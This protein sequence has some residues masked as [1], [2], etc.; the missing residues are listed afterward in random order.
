[1]L[2]REG[3][4]QV[5]SSPAFTSDRYC[6]H[7][8]RLFIGESAVPTITENESL[9]SEKLVIWEFDAGLVFLHGRGEISVLY[10]RLY[11]PRLSPQLSFSSIYRSS[12]LGLYQHQGLW[13]SGTWLYTAFFFFFLSPTLVKTHTFFQYLLRYLP[14]NTISIYTH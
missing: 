11:I 7:R 13:P 4:Q 3:S 12:K 2:G 9:H 10:P 8:T 6:C 5:L 1:M 14:F